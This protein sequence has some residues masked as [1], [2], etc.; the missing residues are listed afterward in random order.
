MV[1]KWRSATAGGTLAAAVTV[2]TWAA[3]FPAI[4]AGLTGFSPWA[5]GTARLL[6][7][8]VALALAAIVLRPAV[9]PL[10]L[11]GRVL[12]AGLVGQALYQGL[13]MTGEVRVPAGT[14]SILIATA[15][16]FSVA[17]AGVLLKEPV[18]PALPGMFVALLGVCFVGVSL[19]VGGGAAALVVLVAAICQGLYHVIVKPLTE[20]L[21]AFAATAWSLWAGAAMCLPLLPLTATQASTAP[22]NA[23]IAVVLL[24]VVSSAIGYVSWSFA[25][26][27]ADVGQTTAALYLVPVVALILSWLWLGERP[28]PLAIAGGALAIVGVMFVRSPGLR[29]KVGGLFPGREHDAADETHAAIPNDSGTGRA[30]G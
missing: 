21:G 8:S 7:A 29:T 5:L 28:Q 6:V 23:L 27:H 1:V 16:I 15:P 2:V 24:G 22:H 11:W 19:G 3:A 12:L 17:A 10:R 18:R 9:P 14:A 4:R 13:L 25:L 26:R 20:S 30:S